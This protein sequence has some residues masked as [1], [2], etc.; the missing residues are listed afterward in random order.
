M[1]VLNT[2]LCIQTNKM[3]C[4]ILPLL[5]KISV[6]SSFISTPT[7]NNIFLPGHLAH[8]ALFESVAYQRSFD[9]GGG[10]VAEE[11]YQQA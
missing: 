2:L 1:S 9:W 5:V 10:D 6:A 11:I 3:Y 7:N 4:T 8:F